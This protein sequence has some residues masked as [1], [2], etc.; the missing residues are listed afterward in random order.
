[1][2]TTKEMIAIM[3][4]YED[5]EAIQRRVL[6]GGIWTNVSSANP[7]WD[8]GYFDYRI[9][10]AEP[11]KVMMQAW[12]RIDGTHF[13][14]EISKSFSTR[15]KNKPKQ[16]YKKVGEPFEFVFPEEMK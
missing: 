2:K 7:V 3:H 5:G 10:P 15:N 8:W 9:R 16:P 1:M 14:E 6:N 13:A 12:Q 4:A 11:R